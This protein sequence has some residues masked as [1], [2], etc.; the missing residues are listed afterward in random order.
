RSSDF[1]LFGFRS[2]WTLS[3]HTVI[4]M[5]IKHLISLLFSGCVL[6]TS[7]SIRAQQTASA[8]NPSGPAR[9]LTA[10]TPPT[11]VL[12]NTFIAPTGWTIKIKGAATL[13][14]APEGN[15]R[16]VLVDTPAKDGDAALAAAW[17]LYAPD[18]KWPLKL[19]TDFPDKD[20]WSRRRNYDYQT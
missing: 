20:G 7:T 16:L 12:G 2:F 5:P 9:P 18:A 17:A 1:C 19:T 10:D 4:F 8:P 3:D 13:L 14:E 15:S 6:L 11:T